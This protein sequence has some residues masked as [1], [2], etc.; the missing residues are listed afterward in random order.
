MQR[1]PGRQERRRRR[2]QRYNSVS[3]DDTE[4]IEGD[5][6]EPPSRSHRT[7]RQ[8]NYQVL[9]TSSTTEL[10]TLN[11][12]TDSDDVDG[13]ANSETTVANN[14]P[15]IMEVTILDFTHKRWPVR[16]TAEQMSQEQPTVFDLKRIGSQV[17]GIPMPQ[18]RLIFQ[19]QLLSDDAKPLSALGIKASG[20]IVHLFPKPR[21]VVV[22]NSST[23]DT[24]S[25]SATT[26]GT[27][28]GDEPSGARIPTIVMDQSELERRSEILVLGHADYVEAVSNVKLFSL[29][30][31]IISSIE[32]LNLLSIYIGANRG[33][34]ENEATAG[35]ANPYYNGGGGSVPYVQHDDFFPDDDAVHNS[36]TNRLDPNHFDTANNST[37]TN[38]LDPVTI[39]LQ[40]W[41]P[42]KYADVIISLLGVY[43]ALLG[44]QASNENCIRTARAYLIGTTITAMG[45]LTYNYIVS[46]EIDEAVATEPDR[47]SSGYPYDTTSSTEASMDPD[48]VEET[49]Y[50][51]AL[52]AMV[53]PAM[54]WCLCIFRAWQFQHL[55]HDAELEAAQRLHQSSDDVT[56]AAEGDRGDVELASL[57]P[58][59]IT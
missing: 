11:N 59:T 45:W 5:E 9:P 26:H 14:T 18:Q 49:A 44:I 58:R 15:A 31:L 46:F 8:P 52:T 25:T 57:P 23:A 36:S 22:E 28:P 38:G 13:A 29:M 17:H 24:D 41:T 50:N 1:P 30:L 2:T 10:R 16:I 27:T 40:T 20:S 6:E 32:L 3:A 42:I 7:S 39:I 21:V 19:G 35:Q 56:Y 48:D 12:T 43:V 37:A 54:V 51:Q 55:L 34:A 4:P 33:D 53:L 47:Y